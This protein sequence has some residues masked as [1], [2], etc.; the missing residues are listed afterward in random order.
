MKG[1]LKSQSKMM[2]FL[3]NSLWSIIYREKK[4]IEYKK[5]IKY[6]NTDVKTHHLNYN[7][8]IPSLNENKSSL[9][10]Y[11]ESILRYVVNHWLITI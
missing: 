10:Y 5:N 2:C 9:D 3:I 7:V 11:D 8:H 4:W 6:I 1:K